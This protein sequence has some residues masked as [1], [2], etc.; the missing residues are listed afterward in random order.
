[1]FN[2][3]L[4][5]QNEHKDVS[6]P[7]ATSDLLHRQTGD[8]NSTHDGLSGVKPETQN[9][10]SDGMSGVKPETQN[11][12][13]D[14]RSGVKPE[15]ENSLS[16][17]RGGVKP[18][19]ENSLSDGLGGVRLCHPE[20][21][22]MRGCAKIAVLFSGGVDSAVITALVDKYVAVPKIH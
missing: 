6:D 1:V 4:L 8:G 2:Q 22:A 16:D 12:L 3:I 9:T 17:G 7:K 14:G 10:L 11:N 5:S 18:E 21:G 15:T 13:S 19:T 20:D